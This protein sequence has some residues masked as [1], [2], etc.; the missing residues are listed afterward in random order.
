[1]FSK[2]SIENALKRREFV[3]HYQPKISL[4]TGRVV[5][6]EALIRWKH[7]TGMLVL[8]SEFIPIA[9]QSSL[10]NRITKYIFSV[11]LDQIIFAGKRIAIPLSFNV[12]ARDF[13]DTTLADQILVA[14]ARGCIDPSILEIEITESQA[15]AGETQVIDN[16]AR[17]GKAG[18][19]LTMDDYGTGYSSIDSL[20]KW[21]FTT[22]KLDQ[23]IIGRMLTSNK[24]ATIVRSSIRLA[25]ELNIKVVAE[26]IET[27]DQYQVLLEYGC[28]LGQGY[29]ISKPLPFAE[30]VEFAV[31]H[32]ADQGTPVGLINMAMLD[33]IEWRK[34]MVSYA[35]K[36][37]ALPPTSPE[38]QGAGYPELPATRCD[39]GK[40]Y[41]KEGKMHPRH[42]SFHA[43]GLRQRELRMI[44]MRIFKKIRAGAQGEQIN[45]VLMDLNSCSIKVLDL[46]ETIENFGLASLYEPA[47]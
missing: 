19:S 46:L 10:I 39:F 31:R 43:L 2:E 33:H 13:E 26:G 1:M 29:L 14:V 41:L 36:C 24:N 21:P 27:Y 15:L 25:H 37:A 23:G 11:L 28:T 38:R 47:G 8:P 35:F 12:S 16:M 30:F 4:I 42:D 6:A 22:I 5:G 7:R 44:G 34:K 40:W 45:P 9:E 18:I 3:L 32:P 17:L 20:S